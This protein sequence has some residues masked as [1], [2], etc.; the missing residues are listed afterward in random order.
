MH[1]ASKMFL[2]INYSKPSIVAPKVPKKIFLKNHYYTSA[3]L[4]RIQR[5][6]INNFTTEVA[7][8]P[9]RLSFKILNNNFKSNG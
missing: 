5:I 4:N 2:L 9:E 7:E 3:R 1:K 8:E 6:N